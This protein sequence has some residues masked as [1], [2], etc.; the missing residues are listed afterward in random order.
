[1][2]KRVF[3]YDVHG[4]TIVNTDARYEEQDLVD[5]AVAELG[6]RHT[7]LRLDP[8]NFLA[9]LRALVVY[10]DAPVYTISY[11][12]QSLLQESIHG[13]GYRISVSGTA[14][15]ELFTGYFDHHLA[16]LYEMRGD[17]AALSAARQAWTQHI[18]P[19][20]RN[21]FLGN[22]D[23]FLENP[24]FRGHIF[25]D[26]AGFA[27]YLTRPW[28]EPFREQAYT[29]SLLRNRMANEMFHEA[30]PVILHEDDLNAMCYSVENR[31]PFL[32]RD[33]FEFC[34]RIPSRHLI[35]DGRAKAVLRDA[36]RGIVPDR[37]LDSRRKVG[38]NAPILDFLKV[39]E[40][41]V[42]AALLDDSPIFEHVR[43]DNIEALLAKPDLP[44][45]ESKFLFYFLNSKIFLEEFAA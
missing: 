12:A 9:R 25:L 1:V 4:F 19:L 11:Y 2:A 24:D 21:P 34:A 40:P 42:R 39:G 18:R 3:N 37:I 35:Q 44:N 15:D 45:S 17:T 28:S 41:A 22:A 23:L 8:A 38:F 7:P 10:H 29:G 26:A 6:I 31:S 43:R 30:V 33:L 5:Y 16:Y 36:M 13:H 20:V 27:Q 32:D 14:A